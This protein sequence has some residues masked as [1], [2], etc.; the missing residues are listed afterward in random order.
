MYKRQE[1]NDK[2]FAHGVA[3]KSLGDCFLIA[4]DTCRTHGK[5]FGKE[6]AKQIYERGALTNPMVA[7]ARKLADACEEFHILVAMHHHPLPVTPK[8]TENDQME[9]GAKLLDVLQSTGKNVILLHGHKHYVSLKNHRDDVSAPLVLSSASLSAYPFDHGETHFSN[10]FHVLEIDINELDNPTG[11]VHSW[12]WGANT[13]AKS[14]RPHM[15]G[16]VHFGGK[17]NLPDLVDKIRVLPKKP[18]YNKDCL[19]YTSP[20]PRD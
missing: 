16:E 3:G 9:N 12:D 1:F 15:P 20:S 14:K 6:A 2:Y 18:M 7:K 11:T 10:Q 4:F 13:W 19:L 8:D 17:P 5:G